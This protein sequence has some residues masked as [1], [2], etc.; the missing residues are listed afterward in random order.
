MR[1]AQGNRHLSDLGIT[2]PLRAGTKIVLSVKIQRLSLS[3]LQTLHDTSTLICT[4][5]PP[6]TDLFDR[7]ITTFA[8]TSLFVH[9]TDTDTRRVNIL[10]RFSHTLNSAYRDNVY[11]FSLNHT[12]M[13]RFA[14]P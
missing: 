8:L 12:D 11:I 1:Y 14:R 3:L 5:V 6:L 13:D 4:H 9:G 10:Y 7:A 2:C